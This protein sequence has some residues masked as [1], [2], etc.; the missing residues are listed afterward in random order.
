ML[1]RFGPL[2]KKL[3]TAEESATDDFE[4][5]ISTADATP[6]V[7]IGTNSGN[8][9]KDTT[10]GKPTAILDE[11]QNTVCSASLV[12][13]DH[14]L[15]WLQYRGYRR[16]RFH[17]TETDGLTRFWTIVFFL[18]AVGL[19]FAG[20]TSKLGLWFYSQVS[21]WTKGWGFVLAPPANEAVSR[22]LIL[23]SAVL[24][25]IAF[26]SLLHVTTSEYFIIISLFLSKIA[27]IASLVILLIEVVLIYPF[28]WTTFLHSELKTFCD[29]EHDYIWKIIS[30][31]FSGLQAFFGISFGT[32]GMIGSLLYDTFY[33]SSSLCCI[34][35]HRCR[36]VEF[37]LIE[38]IPDLANIL[39]YTRPLVP[40]ARV[41]K[42]IKEVLKQSQAIP[43]RPQHRLAFIAF[44]LRTLYRLFESWCKSTCDPS[45]SRRFDAVYLG[46]VDDNCC[47]NGLG[48][49]TDLRSSGETLFGKWEHG[50][51]GITVSGYLIC[52]TNL[53][54]SLNFCFSLARNPTSSF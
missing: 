10:V 25:S 33:A 23:L 52:M 14:M 26:F 29:T 22:S 7:A 48:S 42:M 5:G 39:C 27:S 20:W 6:T 13:Y 32:Y 44:E 51:L 2:R 19:L 35:G 24:S 16:T 17:Q 9:N 11:N 43:P 47:P 4:G 8:P 36:V 12:R 1:K 15:R 30:I 45:T 40:D 37:H 53:Y 34:V 3:T 54:P 38:S 49:W 46:Q 50:W 28:C 31:G 18:I 41:I 21:Y